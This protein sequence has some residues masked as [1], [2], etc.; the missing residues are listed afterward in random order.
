MSLD[1]FRA[2]EGPGV[3]NSSS[4]YFLP[5]EDFLKLQ[6]VPECSFK[7][8]LRFDFFF[9]ILTIRALGV[10]SPTVGQFSC[11]IYKF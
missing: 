1:G 8:K 6:G 11:F 10:D 5:L 2:F 9:T 3:S 4:A 7:A